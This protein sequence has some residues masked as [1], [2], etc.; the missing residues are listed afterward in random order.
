LQIYKLGSLRKRREATEPEL[1]AK[2][3]QSHDRFE[4][5]N[6]AALIETRAEISAR[7]ST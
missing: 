3:E 1:F 5:V 7:V 6:E 4:A 2:S